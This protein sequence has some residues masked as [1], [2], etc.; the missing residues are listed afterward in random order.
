MPGTQVG[1]D[2]HHPAVLTF[3]LTQPEGSRFR[4]TRARLAA[5]G[6]AG[7]AC[8]TPG[9]SLLPSAFTAASRTYPEVAW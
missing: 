6:R 7:S 2:R 1:E 4:G 5:G 9:P 3:D 8:V